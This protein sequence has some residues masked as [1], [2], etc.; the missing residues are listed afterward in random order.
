MKRGKGSSV[1]YG[2]GGTWLTGSYDPETDTVY[3]ATGNPWPDS[4]DRER[5]GRKPVHRIA[6][7]PWSPT[8]ER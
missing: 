7:S 5:G 6:Y 8:P 1:K 4:D 3:W 2:G